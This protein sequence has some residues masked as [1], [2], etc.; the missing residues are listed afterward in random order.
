MAMLA[1]EYWILTMA[2][3]RGTGVCLLSTL[4]SNSRSEAEW[5]MKTGAMK[6]EW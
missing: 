6:L 5:P 2:M 3:R 1:A 4:K